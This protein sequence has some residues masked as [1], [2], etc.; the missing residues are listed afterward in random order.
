MADSDS[1]PKTYHHGKLRETLIEAG[2]SILEE[3]DIRGLSLR[4]VAKRAEVS[5]AAPY[6]HFEDKVDLLSAIAE[7]G[8]KKLSQQFETAIETHADHSHKQMIAIG[9]GY[10]GFGLQHPAQLT[11]M[12]SDLLKITNS[13]TLSDAARYTFQLLVESVS[14]WQEEGLI[15]KGEAEDMARTVWSMVHGLAMLMKEGFFEDQSERFQ[16]ETL[17]KSLNHLMQGLEEKS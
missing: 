5:H 3:E 11:L 8:F 17:M 4:K 13:D 15:R 10:I 1:S 9:K 6:R 14:S 7:E 16:E 2:I 12:F